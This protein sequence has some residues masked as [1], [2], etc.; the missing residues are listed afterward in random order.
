MT[1]SLEYVFSP[2]RL[3]DELH[4]DPSGRGVDRTSLFEGLVTTCAYACLATG[5]FEF[6]LDDVFDRFQQSGIDV[7]YLENLEPFI[8]SGSIHAIPPAVVQKLITLRD[9]RGEPD[10]AE[11]IIWHVD[12]MSLDINQ[13]LNLCH[14]ER[15]YDALIHVYTRSMRDFI[16][17]LVELI[18]L[19]R[20]IQRR[21]RR[22]LGQASDTE[23]SEA[24][25]SGVSRFDEDDVESL[26]PDAYK[27]Y[28]YISDILTGCTYP[29]KDPL[30]ED[31]ANQARN[32]VYSFLFSGRSLAW[33]SR[34]GDLVLTSDEE[35]SVE[36]TYPYL[37]QLLRFDAEAMLGSLDAAFEDPYLNEEIPGKT[38]NRQM[39][40]NL[41]LELMSPSSDGFTSADRIFLYIFVARNLPKYPQF[42]MLP[43]SNLNRILANLATDTDQSTREDRQLAAEYMLSTYTPLDADAM[44][45][46][47]ER[48]GFFRILRSVYKS[49]RRWPFLASTILKDTETSSDIF[50]ELAEVLDASAGGPDADAV[51]SRIVEAVPQLV[52]SG[53]SGLAMLI[54]Q[55]MPSKHQQAAKA[56]AFAKIKQFAYLRCLF[57][58]EMTEAGESFRV[59]P[60]GLSQLDDDIRLTFIE[61]LCEFDRADVISFLERHPQKESTQDAIIEICDRHAVF[62]AVIWQL[63][64]TNR[65]V[66]A[67]DRIRD[68]LES[69]GDRLLRAVQEAESSEGPLQARPGSLVSQVQSVVSMG[70]RIC[71]QRSASSQ[72]TNDSVT[73]EEAWFRLLASVIELVRCFP[74]GTKEDPEDPS[75]LT[76]TS[77]LRNLVPQTLSALI[78]STS[79]QTVSFPRLMRRL[80]DQSASRAN[81]TTSY[82]EF[83]SVITSM[84]GTY[85]FEEDLLRISNKI[86]ASDLFEH[87]EFLQVQR[88][89]GWRPGTAAELITAETG[90]SGFGICAVCGERTFGEALH[91]LDNRDQDTSSS[92]NA[93]MRRLG[94]PPPPIPLTR[95][96][97]LKGKEVYRQDEASYFPTRAPVSNEE[98]DGRHDAATPTDVL[99]TQAVKRQQAVVVMRTGKVFHRACFEATWTG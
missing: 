79:S 14:R 3:T 85:R 53:V 67:F 17:P 21:R 94:L 59:D 37:R 11:R 41:L 74:P 34:G 26:A 22:T 92:A 54:N 57:D 10:L 66:L 88:E 52:E 63:D 62:E 91:S 46:L 78:S 40:L 33:P 99:L 96:P 15:L 93:K 84:L 75:S 24:S 36:P 38:L 2:E 23:E 82:A 80:I 58:P 30:D 16:A 27:I 97:S 5:E 49:E 65:S 86:V 19:I 69:R 6:L 60:A 48:A 8:L 51:V 95:K 1:A 64:R 4:R 42:L 89:K 68:I 87:V 43:P 28:Y 31:E 77:E 25:L 29:S 9:Q 18:G 90:S 61:S 44:L 20:R 50:V 7:I 83:R 32:S 73:P 70:I 98:G 45:A 12:P 13:A 55:Y 39:I 71:V 47:F 81:S 56:L 35:G 76:W 72:R